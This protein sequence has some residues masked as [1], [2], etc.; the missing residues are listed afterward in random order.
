MRRAD[1]VEENALQHREKVES[2]KKM[3]AGMKKALI[4]GRCTHNILNHKSLLQVPVKSRSE[5]LRS[6][7]K[8]KDSEVDYHILN[9]KARN[10]QDQISIIPPQRSPRI[11]GTWLHN[12]LVPIGDKLPTKY[13]HCREFDIV[14]NHY[15]SNHDL[16]DKEDLE[17]LRFDA[18]VAYWQTHDY[19]PIVG[20]YLEKNKEEEF[21]RQRKAVEKVAGSSKMAR[22]PPSVKHSEG[23][24][25]HL[26][27]HEVK[28]AAN[29]ELV[30][31]A[32]ER[33]VKSKKRS[34][35]EAKTKLNAEQEEDQ[36]HEQMLSRISRTT[37]QAERAAGRHHGFDIVSNESHYGRQRKN[38]AESQLIP[39]HAAWKRL[40]QSGGAPAIVGTSVMSKAGTL[41]GGGPTSETIPSSTQRRSSAHTRAITPPVPSLKMP[42]NI[43]VLQNNYDINPPPSVKPVTGGGTTN[44]S[45]SG[46]RTGGF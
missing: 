20:K 5:E 33:G 36:K 12:T 42:A 3:N 17:K 22:L 26:L 25:Y 2:F 11:E 10:M 30:A 41:R 21:Q 6:I 18:Q 23:Q 44:S 45:F 14:S 46:V 24:A 38:V 19:D 31:H 32:G 9:H 34:A 7:P 16:R 29:A 8:H 1:P 37:N 15:R 39:E 4:N 43:T 40:Q 27:H 35:I 28:D 13:E